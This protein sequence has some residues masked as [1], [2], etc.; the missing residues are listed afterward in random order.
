MSLWDKLGVS[1]GVYWVSLWECI[2]AED[3]CTKCLCHKC[4]NTFSKTDIPAITLIVYSCISVKHRKYKADF[5]DYS[6]VDL[7]ASKFKR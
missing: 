1:M 4:E 6:G 7:L 2:G 3:I 5:D